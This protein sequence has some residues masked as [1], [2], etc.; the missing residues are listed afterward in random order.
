M[1]Y[2]VYILLNGGRLPQRQDTRP[3]WIAAVVAIGLI[4]AQASAH[5]KWF[6]SIADITQSPVALARV[7]TPIFALVCC[8]FL[9][10]DF[11]GFLVDGAV[12]QRWP[13]LAS[14]GRL[15]A[16]TEEKQIRLA[17]GAY[18]MLLWNKGAVVLWE[19]GDAIT[20]SAVQDW[21]IAWACPPG[22]PL[23]DTPG[24]G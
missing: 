21:R 11:A 5:V 8:G 14:S 9:L 20:M 2:E 4:P 16:E 12:A 24:S 13:R 7:L 3:G 23:T 10:L 1:E 15:H 19:C 18:F 17:T 22:V 6:C